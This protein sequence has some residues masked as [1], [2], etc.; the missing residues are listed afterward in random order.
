[1]IIINMKISVETSSY[2]KGGVNKSLVYNR[3]FNNRSDSKKKHAKINNECFLALING[4][5]RRK[6]M[7]NVRLN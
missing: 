4:M 7:M 6:K 1:M 5:W 3:V 2:F